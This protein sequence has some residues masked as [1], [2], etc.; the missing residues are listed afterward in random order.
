M[1]LHDRAEY[2]R[3]N[4]ENLRLSS[5]TLPREGLNYYDPSK[6]ALDL[7]S[8]ERILGLLNELVVLCSDLAKA[9][10]DG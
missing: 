1:E 9:I 5:H 8:G 6:E 4:I 10:E 3:H 2:I 7:V